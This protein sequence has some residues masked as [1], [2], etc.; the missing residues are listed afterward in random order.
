[1]YRRKYFKIVMSVWDKGLLMPVWGV[2][3]YC[4]HFLNIVTTFKVVL[5]LSTND[6][7]L[8]W[9]PGSHDPRRLCS[10]SRRHSKWLYCIS[11]DGWLALWCTLMGSQLKIQA[12]SNKF[13]PDKA[14]DS[15]TIGHWNFS[16]WLFLRNSL[17]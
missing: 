13:C 11:I 14:P 2:K 1:M 3:Q 17:P 5:P 9:V 16:N 4:I 10:S 15:A 7:H 12:R 8:I 6:I